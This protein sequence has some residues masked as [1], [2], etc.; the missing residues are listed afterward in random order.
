MTIV[1]RDLC[2]PIQNSVATGIATETVGMTS[3]TIRYL[4][5]KMIELPI[6]FTM[7]MLT[8]PGV[9]VGNYI[10]MILNENPDPGKLK[11]DMKLL[12]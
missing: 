9:V 8:I 1:R 10:L 5:Y 3:G 4:Y 2:I 7:I 6:G 11:L 12:K